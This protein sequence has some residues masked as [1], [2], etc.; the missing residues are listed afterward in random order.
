MY[1]M[2]IYSMFMFMFSGFFVVLSLMMKFTGFMVI[3]EWMVYSFKSMNITFY[4]MI[5]WVSLQFM[6]IVLLI[7]SM[8]MLYSTVYMYGDVNLSRFYLL[9]LMFIISMILMILS[10]NLISIL[11]GWDGLG[12]VSYCLVIYYNNYSSYNSGMVTVLSNRVGDVGILMSIG[13]MS[14]YGSWSIY[15]LD[16][17]LLIMSF[18]LIG[19]MTKS[20]QI[21]FS[22]W[23]PQ[24]MAAPTPVS[25]L[26]HSSTLVT[27]G[28]Y[29]LIRF[30]DLLMNSGMGGLFE[31]SLLTMFMSGL[32]AN[33]EYDLKKII[34][35]STL[36][37]LGL[38]M[39]ILSIGLKN[40][41]LFHMETHAIFKSLL[42]L[43]AGSMIH[44]MMNNQDIRYYGKMNE[45]IPFIMMSFYI[46][47]LSLCGAPFLAGFYSK[48]LIMEIFYS[49][50]SNIFIILM[51]CLSLCFTVSYTFRLMYYVYF[52]SVNFYFSWYLISGSWIMNISMFILMFM[53]VVVGSLMSWVVFFDSYEIFLHLSIKLITLNLCLLG[54]F[55]GLMF[56]IYN[57][58]KFYFL[59]YFISSMWMMMFFYSYIYNPFM[60][61]WRCSNEFDKVWVEFS[62]KFFMIS[63]MESLKNAKVM[64]YS[65]FMTCYLT[66]F[67][68]F[69][70][71]SI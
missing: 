37:Q 70:L 9:V 48:D 60:N 45:F 25:S 54:L 7:S 63:M 15:I 2:L 20:A 24:A 18:V 17:S 40:V 22:Y 21:P 28:V 64:Y 57:F 35:L 43:C 6:G 56:Y 67:Y 16:D 8:V 23:L 31:L 55:M 11:V 65:S 10:P 66:L 29:L 30:N 1:N 14:S 46:S 51:S 4:L 52:G 32:M 12:L 27:A 19:A 5:D 53:S 13:L 26:V 62:S 59:T 33:F 71:I 49:S 68:L 38:M 61:Y 47:S 41:A 42:F 34:A 3:M 44:L 69:Y 58:M 36:S 39:M 50:S